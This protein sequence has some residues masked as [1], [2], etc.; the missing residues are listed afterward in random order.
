MQGILRE[1]EMCGHLVGIIMTRLLNLQVP[2]S[3][4]SHLSLTSYLRL[5]GTNGVTH[6]KSTLDDDKGYG[7]LPRG[8]DKD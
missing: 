1:R 7:F 4:G 2:K 6:G 5:G 3:A 8:R